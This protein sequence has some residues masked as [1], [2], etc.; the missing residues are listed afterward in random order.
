MLPQFFLEISSFRIQRAGETKSFR[1]D[2]DPDL[3][4]GIDANEIART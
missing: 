2:D 3:V 1:V 4:P